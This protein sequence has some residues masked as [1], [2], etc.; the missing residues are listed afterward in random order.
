[1]RLWLL[2]P[3]LVACGVLAAEPALAQSEETY[4]YHIDHETWGDIGEFTNRIRRDGARTDVEASLR[5]SVKILFFEVHRET[6]DRRSVWENGQLASYDSTTDDNGQ[7]IR[8]TGRREAG[9]FLIERPDGSVMAPAEVFPTNVWSIDMQNAR[10]VMGTKTGI[11]VP[12]QVVEGLPQEIEIGGRHLSARYF[13]IDPLADPGVVPFPQEGWFDG[14]DIPVRFA[15][16]KDGAYVTFT[17]T[18][19][20]Q[21]LSARGDGP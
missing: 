2:F 1:M 10:T 8:V 17:L 15:V 13:R 21:I 12:V 14:H 19:Y 7:V 11:V 6:A 4:S 20:E 3:L 18:N 9:A 16:V 5:I